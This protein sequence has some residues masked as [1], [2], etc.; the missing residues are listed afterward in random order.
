MQAVGRT[1]LVT[2]SRGRLE[3]KSWLSRELDASVE[4]VYHVAAQGRDWGPWED[5]YNG[6]FLV[7]QSLLAVSVENC[8]NLKRFLH[9]STV[10]VYDPSRPTTE[11]HE[12]VLLGS[13]RHAFYSIT[14]VMAER[15]VLKAAAEHNLPFTIL[16]PSVVFGPGS[17]SWGL[18]DAQLIYQGQGVLID[19]G[20]ATCGAIYV[21][22][23]VS[24]LPLA[25][26]SPK[27]IGK[28]YNLADNI[29]VTWK[30]YFDALSQGLGLP[31]VKKSIPYWLA[32][33]VAYLSEW[34]WWILRKKNR[35][36]LTLFVLA[37]I[38]RDQKYPINRAF[39][40]FGWRPVVPFQ[41]AM[42]R[43]TKWLLET[44]LYME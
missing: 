14:K 36:V 29:D 24:A 37:L 3:D 12:D 11:C 34:I 9:V 39:E 43:T 5:Y 6:N 32:Y 13:K 20:R 25:A 26:E 18:E 15:A 17:W 28:I 1:G 7:T 27:S 30:A 8:P 35:P 40:D 42:L 22:D 2:F 4:Y 19:H 23:V 44:K 10:D 31:P 16:R 38:G 41:E 21:D 33:L